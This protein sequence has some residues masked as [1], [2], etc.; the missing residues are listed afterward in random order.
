MNKGYK[1]LNKQDRI[2][3]E[4]Q[5]SRWTK[6]KEIAQ[7]IWC[8]P[9]SI[10]REVQR[11]SVKKKKVEKTE[12]FSKEAD[13]KSYQRCWRKNVQ[14]KK[15]NIHTDLKWFII[16]EL[17]SENIYISPKVI[18]SK[19]NKNNKIQI[20]HTSIY[21]WLE[22]WN[23]NKYKKYLAHS[24]KGYKTNKGE[25]KSKIIRRVWIQERNYE[26]ENRSEIGHFEADLIV[27]KKWFKWVILTLVDR[28]TRLPRMFK[29]R[30]KSSS[31]IMKCITKMQDEVWIKSVT[32]DNG[33]EFAKHYLLN[34][35]WIDT[36]FSDPYSPWQ[37]WSIENLNRMVRRT[38]PKGTNFDK[39][40]TQKIRS[41]CYD[42]ANT[43]R[44]ILG[45]LTPNQVHF[46]QK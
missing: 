11:N 42:L 15:I 36:Y 31:N 13:V 8:H 12:Y 20:S 29:L 17:E 4:I 18:A 37:K 22:T 26:N 9:S 14:S 44:E 43:P 27:S 3:I 34:T 6:K 21:A 16:S 33:M 7:I 45:F 40:S 39:V 38:F 35:K 24:Y 19:W 30:D 25:K 2:T 5:L 46:S 32:F 1:Q 28:K 23:G 41:V 10:T